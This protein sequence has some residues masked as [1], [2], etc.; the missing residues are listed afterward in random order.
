MRS[1]YDLKVKQYEKLKFLDRV[2]NNLLSQNN[3]VPQRNSAFITTQNYS[4]N[5]IKINL[6]SDSVI[7]R[8]A[9]RLTVAFVL[10]Y[11]IGQALNPA[12]SNWIIVTTM[13]ILRPNYGL[14]KSRAKSRMSGTI[15]GMFL[16]WLWCFF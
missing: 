2:Y 12:Y 13:V 14:T 7:F 4:W 3:I 10:G 9:I 1:L 16:H 5:T 6:N 8:H 15:L 11:F